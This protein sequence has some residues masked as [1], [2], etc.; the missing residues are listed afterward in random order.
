MLDHIL[1]KKNSTFL[2]FWIAKAGKA[3]SRTVHMATVKPKQSLLRKAT[4]QCETGRCGS[5]QG[6]TVLVVSIS[7]SYLWFFQVMRFETLLVFGAICRRWSSTLC[8]ERMWRA[9]GVSRREISRGLVVSRDWSPWAAS[10]KKGSTLIIGERPSGWTWQ[11]DAVWFVMVFGAK[12]R[13][14]T[15]SW[16]SC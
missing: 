13:F 16:C 14:E 11:F 5:G 2:I 6:S 4:A 3:V 10:Q 7:C 15:D 9:S 12:S 8:R 1:W